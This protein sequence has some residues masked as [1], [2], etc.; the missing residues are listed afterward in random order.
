MLTLNPRFALVTAFIRSSA[1]ERLWNTAAAVVGTLKPS[2][3]ARK[4]GFM[5]RFQ[6]E[7]GFMDLEGRSAPPF[8]ASPRFTGLKLR[9]ISRNRRNF[10]TESSSFFPLLHIANTI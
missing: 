8:L 3:T 5:S 9:A 2:I 1:A 6:C 10:G 4:L 7:K